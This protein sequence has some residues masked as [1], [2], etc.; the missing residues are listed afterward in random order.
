MEKKPT[1]FVVMPIS[2][3][4]GYADGHFRRVYEHLIGPACRQAG[5]EPVRADDVQKTNVIVIDILRRILE[6]D[7]VLCDM[8]AKNA[9]VMYELGI[10][11]AFSK[12]VVLIKDSI[13]ERVFDVQSLR[14]Y[15]YDPSLRIDSVERDVRRIAAAIKETN[16]AD[17]N[18]VT[19]LMQLVGWKPASLPE[20]KAISPDTKIILA[21]L[22]NLGRR[23]GNLETSVVAPPSEV[24]KRR[25]VHTEFDVNG[26]RISGGSRL[27]IDG[28]Q[29]GT[30]A[31]VDNTGIVINGPDEPYVIPPD[32]DEYAKVSDIPF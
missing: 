13:T 32:S 27:Y 26:S 8:S 11:Q 19:S 18:E 16:E 14:T 31:Y 9:N 2:D 28:R 22:E 6:A 21:A 30:L 15:D 25:R 1:C 24:A 17:V 29:I 23:V 20:G 7:L 5:F 4:L 3:G 10:R 12:P